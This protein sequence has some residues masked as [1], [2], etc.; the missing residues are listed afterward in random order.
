MPMRLSNTASESKGERH[1]HNDAAQGRRHSIRHDYYHPFVAT[2]PGR[3][4]TQPTLP[5]HPA[6]IRAATDTSWSAPCI[7]SCTET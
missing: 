2:G 6:C 5:W 1:G 7:I 3:T 4:A